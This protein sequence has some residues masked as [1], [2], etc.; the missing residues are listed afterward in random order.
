MILFRLGSAV[1]FGIIFDLGVVGVW[2]AMGVD[3][4]FRSI[5][6]VIRFRTGK[7][8]EFRAI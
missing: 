3:W 6:F 8:K 2:I 1:L 4:L 7:W 5:A